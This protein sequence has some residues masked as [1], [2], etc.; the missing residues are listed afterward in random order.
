MKPRIAQI[1]PKLLGP[2]S[3]IFFRSFTSRAVFSW[4][5]LVVSEYTLRLKF[6]E[7]TALGQGCRVEGVGFRA[8]S[9]WHRVY[10]VGFGESE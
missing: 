3:V 5:S 10:G 6:F 4:L 2:K 7:F 8:L 9:S 1:G